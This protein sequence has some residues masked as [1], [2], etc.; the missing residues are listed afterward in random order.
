MKQCLIEQVEKE[1]RQRKGRR[2]EA[3]DW[4]VPNRFTLQP[5][6]GTFAPKK[7]RNETEEEQAKS[8]L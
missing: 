8:I 1:Q 3:H 4:I 6:T 5:S 2:D 7:A